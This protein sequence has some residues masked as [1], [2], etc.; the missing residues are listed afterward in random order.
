MEYLPPNLSSEEISFGLV[1]L[2]LF[3]NEQAEERQVGFSIDREGNP[4]FGF[5]E[6]DWQEGWYVIGAELNCYDPIFIDLNDPDFPVYTAMHGCGAWEEHLVSASYGQF[7]SA[8]QTLKELTL[9]Y[10]L[11]DSVPD[12]IVQEFM[13]NISSITGGGY[14]YFWG[15]FILLEERDIEFNKALK[16]DADK[17]DVF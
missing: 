14:P 13:G 3:S 12:E 5:D 16:N 17:A 9:K 1:H 6:G 10:S 7:L 11:A 15:M 8:T 4:L 2:A